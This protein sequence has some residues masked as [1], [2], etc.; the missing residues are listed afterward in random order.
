MKPE[1]PIEKPVHIFKPDSIIP[2]PNTMPEPSASNPADPQLTQLDSI[3]N[4]LVVSDAT[5]PEPLD[6]DSD[7]T[8]EPDYVFAQSFSHV[9]DLDLK[10]CLLIDTGSSIDI[11]I[12]NTCISNI[13]SSSR[14]LTTNST[15][16]Y[17]QY[18]HK[19][20]FLGFLEF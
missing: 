15:G 4:V 1:K 6:Y 10:D 11:F 8:L 12:S 13:C 2:K 20:T 3:D 14:P 19:A 18:I 16:S 5:P 7:D 17:Q 9:T